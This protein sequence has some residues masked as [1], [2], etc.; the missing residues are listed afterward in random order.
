MIIF[1]N[2]RKWGGSAPILFIQ[3]KRNTP[4]LV[5]PTEEDILD[6]FLGY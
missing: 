3:F 5:T 6:D 2:F 4:W 1:I